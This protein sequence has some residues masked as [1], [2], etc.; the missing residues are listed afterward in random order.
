VAYATM[1]GADSIFILSAKHGLLRFNTIIEPY[2]VTLNRMPKA[3]REA[4]RTRVLEQLRDAID[5]ESDLILML[6][7][8]RYREGLTG[9]M[10]YVEVPMLGLS[11]GRQLKFLSEALR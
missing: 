5:F 11:Q 3:A 9:L 10:K 8:E 7:S 2:E 1:R 4:W 6:A